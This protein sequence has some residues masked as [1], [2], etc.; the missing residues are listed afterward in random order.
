MTH[1]AHVKRFVH[2]GISHQGL[3]VCLQV[4][5]LRQILDTFRRSWNGMN[6]SLAPD[7]RY[8]NDDEV[9]G[10]EHRTHKHDVFLRRDIYGNI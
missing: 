4:V 5:H 3:V 1:L 2:S 6:Q 10:D 8:S 9:G 7:Q